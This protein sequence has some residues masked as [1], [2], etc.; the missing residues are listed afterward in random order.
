REANDGDVEEQA[1]AGQS[2]PARY[3]HPHFVKQVKTWIEPRERTTKTRRIPSEP[4]LS[5]QIGTERNTRPK[6]NP[7]QKNPHRHAVSNSGACAAR[8]RPLDARPFSTAA[9]PRASRF[10]PTTK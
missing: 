7:I 3:P 6:W 2:P 1:R 9:T 4:R 5:F 8:S 10:A